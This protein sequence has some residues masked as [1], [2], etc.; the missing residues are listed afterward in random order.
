MNYL[1]TQNQLE[2]NL[3][4]ISRLSYFVSIFIQGCITAVRYSKALILKIR[5]RRFLEHCYERGNL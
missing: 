5:T 4:K 2:Q 1:G 3:E